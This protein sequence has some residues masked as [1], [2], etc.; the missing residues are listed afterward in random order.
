METT[1]K[2]EESVSVSTD[3]TQPTEIASTS[4]PHT[5]VEA[6]PNPPKNEVVNWTWTDADTKIV[7]IIVQTE[8]NL[9]ISYTSEKGENSIRSLVKEFLLAFFSKLCFRQ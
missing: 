6:N 5:V 8:L 7:C 1:E 2:P 4:M 9:N 3:M